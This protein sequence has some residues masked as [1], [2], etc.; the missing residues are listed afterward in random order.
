MWKGQPILDCAGNE[1]P[2]L[3]SQLFWTHPDESIT[4]YLKEIETGTDFS[5]FNFA[6]TSDCSIF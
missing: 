5:T 4:P 1:I 3:E 6:G 2:V